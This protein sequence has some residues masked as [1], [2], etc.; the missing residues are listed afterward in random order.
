MARTSINFTQAEANALET[1]ALTNGLV[2]S[3]RNGEILADF[4]ANKMNADITAETL[5]AAVKVV[6]GLVWK[7]AVEREFDTI[8][9]QLN[10]SEKSVVSNWLERQTRMVTDGD[11]G[12]ENFSII[13]GWLRARSYA[14]TDQN[15]NTALT[16]VINSGQ[17]K[18]HWTPTPA[19][20]AYEGGYGR[21]SNT[22]SERISLSGDVV[23][24]IVDNSKEKYYQRAAESIQGRNHAETNELR[25]IVVTNPDG[26]TNWKATSEARN[27]AYEQAN[28]PRR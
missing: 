17:R 12:L 16:N 23:E 6:Q 9:G 15:L 24:R 22:K 28:R 10:G 19:T 13:V 3:E 21:H 1:F 8:A 20:P 2:A 4:I 11:P 25:K 26:T 18:L 27:R 7:T 5:A 14:I